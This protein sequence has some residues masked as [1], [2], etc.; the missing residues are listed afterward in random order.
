MAIV[1]GNPS[2]RKRVKKTVCSPKLTR[3]ANAKP[4]PRFV[5]D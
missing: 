3:W 1:L 4:I 5:V 2:Q